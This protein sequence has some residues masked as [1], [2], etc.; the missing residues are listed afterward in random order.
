MLAEDESLLEKSMTTAD[1]ED[2]DSSGELA[3]SKVKTNSEEDNEARVISLATGERS[4]AARDIINST[5]VIGNG[6]VAGA[7]VLASQW[8]P[9]SVPARPPLVLGREQDLFEIKKRLGIG[10]DDRTVEVQIITAVRGW[11]GIGKTTLVSV[12]AHDLDVEKAFP[13]GVLWKSLGKTPS[14]LSELVAWGRDLGSNELMNAQNI[15][16]ASA[17]LAALLRSRRMLLIVDDVWEAEHAKAFI[18]GGR[19]CATIFTTRSKVVAQSI[20]PTDDAVYKLGVLTEESAVELLGKLAPSVTAQY[21]K[22]CQELVKALDCLP[23][24]LQVAGRLLNAE[25]DFGLDI[26]HLLTELRDGAKLLESK[27]PVDLTDVEKETTP[28]IAALLSKST[29]LLDPTTRDCFAY[30]GVFVPEPASFDID[31]LKAMWQI[32]DPLPVLHTLV[33]RG[34]LEPSGSGRFQLHALLV[35]HAR[36]HLT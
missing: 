7:N 33:K 11:P 2:N 18:V 13:D 23:L 31:A 12:L 6:N 19:D 27:A 28:T 21:T 5:V 36:S 20:A 3:A 30:L 24:A 26:S 22:E 4:L 35:M 9:G 16:E 14:I 1:E 32:P 10:T 29:Q 15:T 8:R 34:L 17:Q 25:S